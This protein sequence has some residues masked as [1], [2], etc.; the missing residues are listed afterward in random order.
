MRR[1]VLVA[2]VFGSALMMAGTSRAEIVA[3]N[4]SGA[5]LALGPKGT[6]FVAYVRGTRIM[7]SSRAGAATWRATAAAQTTA[8]ATVKAFKVGAAGPVALVQSADDRTLVLV[9]KRGATWQTTRL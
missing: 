7:V 6:P 3:H 9:R 5:L 8:G 2:L 4:A 1:V